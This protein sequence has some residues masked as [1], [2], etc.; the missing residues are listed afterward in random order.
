MKHNENKAEAIDYAKSISS[1]FFSSLGISELNP[2]SSPVTNI[3]TENSNDK[4]L[5][6]FLL[7]FI[8]MLLVSGSVMSEMLFYIFIAALLWGV[9]DIGLNW[10]KEGN[11]IY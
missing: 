4:Y 8:E 7:F 2:M 5:S 11:D 3:T 9:I 10:K 6:K 1:S